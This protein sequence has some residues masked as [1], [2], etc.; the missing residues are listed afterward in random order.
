MDAQRT[1]EERFADLP[2]WPYQSRYTTVT[3]S[4]ID[5]PLRLA[6]VDVGPEAGRPT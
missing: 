1:P 2:D 5:V 3:A 6:Y 4:G